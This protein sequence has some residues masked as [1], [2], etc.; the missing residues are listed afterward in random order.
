MA[1]EIE[2]KFLIESPPPW[3]EQHERVEIEQ[4]YLAVDGAPG[5]V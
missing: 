5:D 2:R 3:L 4:G 1:L